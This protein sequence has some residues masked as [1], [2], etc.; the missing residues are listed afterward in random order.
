MKYAKIIDHPNLV[1]DLDSGA[2]LNVDHNARDNF[3][4][5]RDAKRKD[6]IRIDTLENDVKM[7]NSKLDVILELLRNNRA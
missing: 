7:L 5:A 3:L 6:K 2:V 4:K 1:R